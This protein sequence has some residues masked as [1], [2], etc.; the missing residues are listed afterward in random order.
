MLE[1][2][3]KGR[4]ASGNIM[5]IIC[6]LLQHFQHQK[7]IFTEV[8]S[9]LSCIYSDHFVHYSIP[10]TIPPFDSILIETSSFINY[11]IMCDWTMW[12]KSGP[13]QWL[14]YKKTLHAWDRAHVIHKPILCLHYI[15]P[16]NIERNPKL[17]DSHYHVQY[18]KRHTHNLRVT[19]TN[20][21]RSPSGSTRTKS[22]WSRM[23]NV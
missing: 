22:V 10:I 17:H 9:V 20:K 21:H 4:V 1:P 23:Q 12:F 11:N 8:K 14:H 2:T 16:E 19:S 18:S 6:V 3:A 13:T 5:K 7:I 15:R